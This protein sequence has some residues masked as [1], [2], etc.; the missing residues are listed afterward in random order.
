MTSVALV[1][2]ATRAQE[3][4]VPINE[5]KARA[6]V[7]SIVKRLLQESE[8]D[9][10]QGVKVSWAPIPSSEDLAK[11]AALGDQAIPVLE[12]LLLSEDAR[13]CGLAVRLMCAR[14]SDKCAPSL[15][16]FLRLSRTSSACRTSAVL[17]LRDAPES[18]VG[19]VLRDLAEKDSD[20]SVR[21]AAQ[22][23]VGSRQAPAKQ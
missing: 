3:Q 21:R 20:I 13:T 10:G 5:K 19:D 11:M 2:V 17:W 14:G 4:N 15:V 23:S 12:D 22:T 7:T 18:I 16:S 1:Q 9:M 8:R 6:E